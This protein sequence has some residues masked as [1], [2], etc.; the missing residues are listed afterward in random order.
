MVIVAVVMVIMLVVFLNM[1]MM[2]V[3]MVAKMI[4]ICE[5]LNEIGRARVIY[6]ECTRCVTHEE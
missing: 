5:E 6:T 1:I 3:R 2:V 4:V